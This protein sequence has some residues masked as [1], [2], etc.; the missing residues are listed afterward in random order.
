MQHIFRE[1]DIRGIFQEDLNEKTVKLIGYFLGKRI[2]KRGDYAVVTYDARTHSPQLSDWLVSGLNA[3]EVI[4]LH[5][6]LVPTPVNYFCNFNTFRVGGKEVMP[7]GGIQITGSHNPPEYNGFK[8]TID[9]LPF[10]GEDIYALGREVEANS[11]I[12]IA[13]ETDAIEIPALEKYVDY[14]TK[15]FSALKGF[16][17]KMAIDCGNGAAGV[18]IEPLLEKLAISAT[19]LYFEPDGTFPNHHPDP[20]E[21]ENLAD[22]KKVLQKGAA[23][24][25][26]FDG[27][28]DRIAFLSRKHNFKGDILA[29]FFA[30]TMEN[31]TV[32]GEVKC[33]QVMY[34]GINAIGKAIMH[35]TG[36]SNLK[37]LLK[38]TGADLAAEVSGHIFFND[39]Y[40][41]YDDAIYTMLRI[42]EMLKNGFDFD[43]EYEKLP[44]LYSTDEIKVPTTDQ[45]KFAIID[46][47]KALL[48]ERKSEL[49]IK[50]IV[51]IDGVRVIFENGWGLVRASNTTPILVTRFEAVS[52]EA[53][54][55]IRNL[56][57][58]MIE[59][60]KHTVG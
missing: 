5:G 1:Y 43:A 55:R 26:A 14:L 6:G 34:D 13:D 39:R 41:G 15:E 44:V 29:L 40:F 46:A 33:S 20:S 57:N 36:H 25:F 12:A 59:E 35:K 7:A 22:L 2:K 19:K 17:P 51:T 16:D 32:I 8:I 9:Q 18:A 21:E 47:L 30:K 42:L 50:D 37:V 31:P 48:N 10:Y 45:K 4:V 3:A 24:G 58:E 52:P 27:D 11:H 60:A 38:E 23:Y 54:E 53:L 28:G 56:L 49:G